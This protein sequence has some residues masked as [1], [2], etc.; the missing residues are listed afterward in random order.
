MALNGC[1]VTLLCGGVGGAKLA[2]GLAHVLP[3]AQLRIIVNTGDDFWH[4]GLRVCPDIDTVLYTLA[5]IANPQ[6]GWGLHGDTRRVLDTLRE[7]YGV[8]TWFQL[9]DADIATQIF[10]SERLRAGF[11]LSETIAE[12]ACHLG[13]APA[14]LPMCD[15]PLPTMLDC[16][17]EGE[18]DFQTYF[19]RRRCE[20][21]V[22][23]LRYADAKYAT[24]TPNV[25]EA[26]EEADIL[27]IAPSNP[28][29]SIAPI[30]AIPDM[31]AALQ[32][33]T[34]PRVAVSPIVDGRALKGPAAQLMAQLGLKVSAAGVAQYYGSL[35]NGFVYDQQ[36][37]AQ[38]NSGN[39]NDCL[40]KITL[41]T[42]MVD[43]QT[44]I[45]LASE[46]LAW[47]E[48]WR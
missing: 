43:T 2:L 27:L 24:I 41:D 17:D 18:L 38:M 26:I 13:V 31:R 8:D 34:I 35:L 22:R 4:Y 9:G 5:G 42:L 29:L 16:V 1:R 3:P 7:R 14:V 46:L 30:L 48:S 33:R 40:R 47:I 6:T 12:Q 37:A 21:R 28:W 45:R 32:A 39:P 36:D 19:V 10:R 15:E 20:P 11:S 23:S 44:K 25:R